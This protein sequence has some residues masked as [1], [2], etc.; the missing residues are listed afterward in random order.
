MNSDYRAHV[1]HY[2]DRLV[3]IITTELMLYQCD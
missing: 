2:P 3:M 1:V